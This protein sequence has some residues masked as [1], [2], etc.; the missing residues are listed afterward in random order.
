MRFFSFKISDNLTGRSRFCFLKKI[1]FWFFWGIKVT[2]CSRFALIWILKKFCRTNSPETQKTKTTTTRP[3][4]MGTTLA[5]FTRR[6]LIFNTARFA[7]ESIL[8][9]T[10]KKV[11]VMLC[12]LLDVHY[13]FFLTSEFDSTWNSAF[14]GNFGRRNKCTNQKKC[15]K[16]RDFSLFT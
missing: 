4:S 16:N 2:D 15:S 7:L 10:S 11:T 1:K 8:T 13:F 12:N 14:R 9:V 5:R 6:Q 3:L